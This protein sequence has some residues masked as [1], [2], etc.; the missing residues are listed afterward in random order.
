M[1]VWPLVFQVVYGAPGDEIHLSAGAIMT[2]VTIDVPEFAG[3]NLPGIEHRTQFLHDLGMFVGMW[4]EFELGMEIRIGQLTDASPLDNAT[5]VGTL[6]FRTKSEILHA[7]LVQRGLVGEKD[8]W[9]TSASLVKRNVLMHG[10]M[11]TENDFELFA[12]Y[13]RTVSGATD[14][15][16][17]VKTADEFRKDVTAFRQRSHDLLLSLGINDLMV[18]EY[19]AAARL[20]P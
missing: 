7:L 20:S 16:S 8:A 3:A 12:I 6:Q 9:A 15:Q 17:M 4:S 18:S 14:R 2:S 5:V 10:V 13:K 1:G 19:G 11:S